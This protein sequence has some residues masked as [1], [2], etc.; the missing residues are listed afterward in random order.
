M[1]HQSIVSFLL[2][3]VVINLL[4]SILL[5]LI[6]LF[7]SVHGDSVYGESVL[8][9]NSTGYEDE[10]SYGGMVRGSWSTGDTSHA[11]ECSGIAGSTDC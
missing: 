10:R 3:A 4:P 5:F 11:Y 2:L 9:E 7:N 6:I 8:N 1:L